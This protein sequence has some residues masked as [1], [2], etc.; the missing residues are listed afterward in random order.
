MT[1]SLAITLT[2]DV[3]TLDRYSHTGD[4]SGRSRQVAGQSTLRLTTAT[5]IGGARVAWS[6]RVI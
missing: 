1:K 5:P 2:S 6:H 3:D 4:T